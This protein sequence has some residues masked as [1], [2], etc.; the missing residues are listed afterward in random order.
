MLQ[1]Y[2]TS[3]NAVPFRRCDSANVG[4]SRFCKLDDTKL[5]VPKKFG[6]QILNDFAAK[7]PAFAKSIASNIRY[8]D[9]SIGG[10]DIFSSN[11]PSYDAYDE[12]IAVV[13]GHLPKNF[14]AI[15]NGAENYG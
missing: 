1:I 4:V 12:D 11:Y 8:Y 7:P 13:Q 2:E 3:I 15:M 6:Q 14:F 10:I 9:T 5:P